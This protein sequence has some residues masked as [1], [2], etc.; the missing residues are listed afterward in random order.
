MKAYEPISHN[1]DND[2]DETKWEFNTEKESMKN[3]LHY[4]EE[5]I[6]ASS[7]I[8]T[9]RYQN[10][11]DSFDDDEIYDD[12]DEIEDVDE[13]ED[14]PWEFKS[15]YNDGLPETSVDHLVERKSNV[16]DRSQYVSSVLNAVENLSQWKAVKAKGVTP[17]QYMCQK[18]NL[19]S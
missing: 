16:R 11:R 9:H 17:P 14:F 5:D 15:G 12:V 4:E 1:N 19:L 3:S 2:D 13:D 8:S 10:C 6:I 7:C 18:E